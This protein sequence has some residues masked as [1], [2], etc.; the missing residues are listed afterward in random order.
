MAGAVQA[1][2]RKGEQREGGK[3]TELL[4][5]I[6]HL[7]W[8][9]LEARV[10]WHTVSDCICTAWGLSPYQPR[11]R[12]SCRELDGVRLTSENF[13]EPKKRDFQAGY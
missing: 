1:A 5:S 3:L 10:T 7:P 6:V 8:R 13:P 2:E 11:I 4:L 9:L 12:E